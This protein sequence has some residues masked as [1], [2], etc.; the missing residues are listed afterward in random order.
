M[1]SCFHN[2]DTHEF[3]FLY[4]DSTKTTL[5][6]QKYGPKPAMEYL[7]AQR[8]YLIPIIKKYRGE[9]I[10]FV[11]DSFLVFFK[12]SIDA[13]LAAI[14]IREL[15]NS[16]P[17]II[18]ICKESEIR[19]SGLALSY[20]PEICEEVGENQVED[21]LIVAHG[22]DLIENLRK[23]MFN[24]GLD[25]ETW[26]TV[27][28]PKESFIKIRRSTVADAKSLKNKT[29]L[30]FSSKSVKES[31]NDIVKSHS[32]FSYSFL[33][34]FI[35]I[36]DNRES[37]FACSLK[38]YEANDKKMTIVIQKADDSL[39]HERLEI[40]SSAGINKACKL[41]EDV[42]KDVAGIRISKESYE[43]APRNDFN[44]LVAELSGL[45]IEYWALQG[46]VI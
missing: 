6:T 30:V 19:L 2:R 17:E 10:K 18:A 31:N 44:L 32:G 15:H 29:I 21:C 11:W 22:E 37:A 16:N 7:I 25:Y 5:S 40:I 46:N 43:E 4:Q 42:E 12:S 27:H 13:A 28:L 41:L 8:K 1:G 20:D 45:K 36:F 9:V 23:E 33:P 26:T 3:V 38:L 35:W 34:K 39:V 14:E 24:F